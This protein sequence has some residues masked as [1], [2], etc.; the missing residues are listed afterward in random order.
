MYVG[1]SGAMGKMGRECARV[2]GEEK[3]NIAF[4][5]DTQGCDGI[6]KS[7]D[8]VSKDVPCDV[9][10]DFSSPEA[11]SD[12]LEFCRTR[13]CGAV[14]ATTGYSSGQIEEIQQV[15]DTVPFLVSRNMSIGINLIGRLCEMLASSFKICD[16]EIVETHHRMKKD[17]PSGTALFLADMLKKGMGDCRY[18]YDRHMSEM[19]GKGEIG[20]HS[21]RGGSVVGRHEV[22]F[23]MAGETLCLS[24]T[25]ENRELFA[26]GA[27]AAAEFIV[28]KPCGFFTMSDLVDEILN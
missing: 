28:K 17:A 8:T 3:I 11:L 18:V 4:S 6:Y 19:R 10:V 5:V 16:T 2:F 12:I 13:G 26:R 25:A 22:Y 15:S 14:L 20:I 24:H 21:L 23:F 7:F 9:V 1:L 27:L